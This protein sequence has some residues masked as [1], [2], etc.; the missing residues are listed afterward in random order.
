MVTSATL[1]PRIRS[2][3]VRS[4]QSQPAGL[5]SPP[6]KTPKHVQAD[7]P[8]CM[9]S[10]GSG[11]SSPAPR[12]LNPTHCLAP[13]THTF[14][15]APPFPLLP[16][17]CSTPRPWSPPQPSPQLLPLRSAEHRGLLHSH[18]VF[19]IPLPYLSL[20]LVHPHGWSVCSSQSSHW[21]PHPLDK[22]WTTASPSQPPQ[23]QPTPRSPS[24]LASST[25]WTLC[26]KSCPF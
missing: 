2:G 25:H 23:A 15:K 20:H 11:D 7:G 9:V 1:P 13:P 3:H 22:L 10:Q 26:L 6:W 12:P 19:L 8:G 4:D 5:T 18:L 24:A 17:P 14:P 21:S 16:T